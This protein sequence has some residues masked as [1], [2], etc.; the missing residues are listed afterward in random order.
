MLSYLHKLV[1]VRTTCLAATLGAA[2]FVGSGAAACTPTYTVQAGD[3]LFAIAE[4][5][6]GDVNKWSLIFYGNPALE[7][8]NITD[9]PAGAV[10]EIPCVPDKVVLAPDPTPLKQSNAE[11]T[12]VTG[13]NYAP[14]VDL[15]WAGQ[16]MAT[17]IVNASLENMPSPVTY[18]IQWENDWSKHLDPMLSNKSVDMGFPWY[19]P[20]CVST[21]EDTLC[22]DFHFS[23]P[24][25]DLVFL[26]FVRSDSGIV[27]D[28]DSDMHGKIIC[29][30]EGALTHDLDRVGRQWLSKGLVLLVQA[31]TAQSCFEQLAA[32]KVDAVSVNEFLGVKTMFDLG[33]TDRIVPLPRPVSVEGMHVVISKSHWRGTTHIFRFN[34]GLAKLK[35][36]EK[37]NEIVQRHLALFWEQIRS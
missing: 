12:L 29:R 2:S 15:N 3:T 9:L 17:E 35:Q 32:G 37:Y 34:A 11:L 25:I 10:I 33:I 26:F 19:R 5:N 18:S 4:D 20:D 24:L 28:V 7:G 31:P 21:P 6:L 13:S 27:F 36:T 23:D 14:F 16:G 30:P 22:S 1:S 8:T